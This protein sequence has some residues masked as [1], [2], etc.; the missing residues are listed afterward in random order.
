MVMFIRSF[1]VV[2]VFLVTMEEACGQNLRAKPGPP[3]RVFHSNSPE[4]KEALSERFLGIT[5]DGEIIP[6]LFPIQPTGFST[7]PIKNAA[8][9]FLSSLSEEQRL[10]CTFPIEGN[11]WRRWSNIDISLYKREGIGLQ[12]LPKRQK[13]LAFEMLKVSLSPRGFQKTQE[14]MLMEEYLGRITNG[15]D[16]LGSEYYWLTFF[17]NLSSAGPWGWQLDG[18]HLVINYFVL[19]DQV[20][21]TPTFMGSE[22]TLIETGVHKGTRTFEKE[23]A[24]GLAFYHSLDADQKNWATL[25][26]RKNHHYLQAEAFRDNAVIPYV[27][28]KATDLGEDQ[29]DHLTALIQEYVGNLRAEHASLKMKEVFLHI[30]ETY[31]A[32]IGALDG[33]GPFY[34]RIHSPVILIEFDHQRPVALKGSKPT[35]RHVHAIVRTPN[36]N[37]YGK[38][39]LRQHLERDH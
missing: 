34:Y 38:D 25:G 22:P 8:K 24:L 39:L 23:E 16:Y 2:L 29:V 13:E 1:L 7:L 35:R 33:S 10:N 3:I 26:T 11:E 5:V 21:M 32:W 27:G 18:H 37:D 36:G 6:G 30:D 12:S 20:V 15:T 14:I 19:G 17:G 28:I 4:E 31:F 9:T